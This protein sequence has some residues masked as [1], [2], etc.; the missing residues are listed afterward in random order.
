MSMYQEYF[1][2]ASSV[3]GS[4]VLSH[5][6]AIACLAAYTTV[7]GTGNNDKDITSRDRSRVVSV[8]QWTMTLSAAAHGRYVG[9][10]E[11]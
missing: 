3:P 6:V 4:H 10:D 5:H 1:L 11:Y 7:R 2:S 8:P 9:G